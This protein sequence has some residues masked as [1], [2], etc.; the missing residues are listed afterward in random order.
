MCLFLIYDGLKSVLPGGRTLVRH[1]NLLLFFLLFF[2]KSTSLFAQ[3]DSINK[4]NDSLP[5]TSG[6]GG[7]VSSAILKDSL[8]ISS[9]KG[10]GRAL[11]K[12]SINS[13]ILVK[14]DSLKKDSLKKHFLFPPTLYT[15][16]TWEKKAFRYSLKQLPPVIGKI[17]TPLDTN[18]QDPNVAY[19][20]S[21]VLPGWG[22]AYN[23]SYWKIP[24][25]YAGLGGIGY[26]IY[27]NNVEYKKY[28]TAYYYEVDDNSTT[29][30]TQVDTRY[31]E[32]P[33][34]S[35]R[36]ARNQFRTT[37]DQ[38]IIIFAVA[39]SLQIIE[40]YVHAHLKY[41]DVSNNMAVHIQPT[42]IP[43]L[44]ANQQRFQGGKA[45]IGLTLRF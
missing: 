17:L 36:T 35:L 28:Q 40:A 32:V 22:Q 10:G 5:K 41:F 4:R 31:A 2:A 1:K 26:W 33:T 34:E 13:P 8:N 3:N 27:Y 11:L 42:Y 24:I 25:I 29:N 39:Y 19:M 7:K 9:A 44:A 15:I 38:G 45:G 14:S 30:K 43:S 6:K 23:R 18:R 37:R 12:D 21:L 20:R 16:R